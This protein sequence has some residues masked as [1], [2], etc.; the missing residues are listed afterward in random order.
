MVEEETSGDAAALLPVSMFNVQC[1]SHVISSTCRDLP[2][3][4]GG[5][6]APHQ[7][8][9]EEDAKE[10]P[11]RIVGHIKKWAELRVT[12]RGPL[13]CI[14]SFGQQGLSMWLV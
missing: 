14:L 9:S 7:L 10:N 8:Q 12:K 1:V 6:S 4:A 13:T 11:T 2:L 5:G 3:P